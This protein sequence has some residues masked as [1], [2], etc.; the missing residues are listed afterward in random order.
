[1]GCVKSR[2]IWKLVFKYVYGFVLV[3]FLA[4]MLPRLVSLVFFTRG[5]GRI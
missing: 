5:G 3:F 2:R 4:R 1:M